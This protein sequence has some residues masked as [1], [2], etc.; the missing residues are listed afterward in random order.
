MIKQY[1]EFDKDGF[2]TRPIF[3][4]YNKTNRKPD[5]VTDIQPP[6]GLCRARFDGFKWIDTVDQSILI[7]NAITL[8]LDEIT[9]KCKEII[10][11]GINITTSVGPKHFSLTEVDQINMMNQ[12]DQLEKALDGKPSK[13]NLSKGVAYHAD[14]ELCKFWSPQ[15]FGTIVKAATEFILYHQTYCNH[16][17][18][19]TKGLKD[20][21]S[22][23]RIAYGIELPEDLQ[24]SLDSI[25][26][27]Y[28]MEVNE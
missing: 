21:Y 3:T 23:N 7:E 11:N 10:Y 16:L 18:E 8:K 20:V 6:N 2:Y 13:I 26:G 12:Y 17:R 27:E 4:D 24:R 25:V 22:I 14:G 15:D 28:N 19:Y 9:T 5:N 1:F